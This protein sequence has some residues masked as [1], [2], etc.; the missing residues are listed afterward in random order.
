MGTR[1][2]RL[3]MATLLSGVC[4]GGLGTAEAGLDKYH[5]DERIGFKVRPP[6]D[7]SHVA[8]GADEKWIV[9]KFTSDRTYVYNDDV[10]GTIDHRPEMTMVTFIES[11]VAKSGVD[12]SKDDDG[13]LVLEFNNPYKDYPDFLK[14]TFSGGGWYVSAETE[15]DHKGIPVTMLE[16]KVEKLTYSGPK[17]LI[18][19]VYHLDGVDLAVQFEVLEN[20]VDKLRGDIDASFKSL[21]TIER[22]KALV[23][24]TTGDKIRLDDESKLTLEE[25]TERRKE[26]ENRLHA[27]AIEGLPDDWEVDRQGRFLVLLH[28]DKKFAQRIVKQA[29]AMW[30][31]LDKTFPEFGKGEY[32]PR[33]IVRICKD[34]AEESAYLSGT[35]WGNNIDIT[36]HR[37][38][39]AGA[40]SWEF[41]YV[42]GRVLDIW[43]GYRNRDAWW[44]APW[45]IRGGMRQ[46]IGAAR[47]KGSRVEF[48]VDDWERDGLRES[49]R[50]NELTPPKELVMLTREQFGENPHRTKQSAAFVR[51]LLSSRSRK[52]SSILETYLLGVQRV[53]KEFDEAEE[54]ER[55]NRSD[56]DAP[57]TEEEEEAR[58]RERSKKLE[59]KEQEFLDKVFQHTFGDWSD[60]DW[61]RL[62]DEYFKSI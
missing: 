47:L 12:A 22:T 43:F 57:K 3:G 40:G 45:W 5:E 11:V 37:D 50:N 10:S 61:R 1:I 25:R 26:T 49:A 39:N 42:N 14:R 33:P 31:W 8:M 36:T 21:R 29:D 2:A 28:G 17:R 53:T 44:A 24:E 58:L 7:W 20:Q 54:A 35:S 48:K 9:G 16:I 41:E 55:K 23:P 30:D 62:Q 46:V 19:W 51:F 38:P 15:G 18:T 6:K 34:Q 27:K 60:K 52:T 4:L 32:I 13:T 59:A 56:S